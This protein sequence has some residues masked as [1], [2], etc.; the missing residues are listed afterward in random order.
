M[1]STQTKTVSATFVRWYSGKCKNDRI[2]FFLWLPI[3]FWCTNRQLTPH[4]V[5]LF[6][7]VVKPKYSDSFVRLFVS[8]CSIKNL[9]NVP[10]T[11][12]RL[13]VW[14]VHYKGI[15]RQP[16]SQSKVLRWRTAG[17]VVKSL[18]DMFWGQSV[19]DGQDMWLKVNISVLA[20][21]TSC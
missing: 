13:H 5:C 11:S 9:F 19:F 17:K 4:D 3:C 15:A 8:L 1:S 18:V 10:F 21:C 14:E 7:G 12:Y 2:G 6:D 16:S 20:W